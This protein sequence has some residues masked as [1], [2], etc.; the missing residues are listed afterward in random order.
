MEKL[1]EEL[2]TLLIKILI[3]ALVAVS[4]KIAI[5]SRKNPMT[6]FNVITSIVIGVGSAYLFSGLVINNFSD[7]W[8]PLMIALV[9]ISGEKIGNWLIYKFNIDLFI[10]ALIEKYYR[11]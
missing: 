9:T 8:V 6:L 10:E 3:P 2:R 4:I 1:S 7:E 11:K 5:T